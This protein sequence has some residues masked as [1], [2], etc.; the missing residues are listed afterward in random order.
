MP[1]V[2]LLICSMLGAC[3]VAPPD[4][5]IFSVD[6]AEVEWPTPGNTPIGY[7]QLGDTLELRIKAKD[8]RSLAFVELHAKANPDQPNVSVSLFLAQYSLRPIVTQ[9]DLAIN[10]I[11]REDSVSERVNTGFSETEPNWVEGIYGLKTDTL[12]EF[13]LEVWDYQNRHSREAYRFV[14]EE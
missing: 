12:Q 8:N 14:V 13:I 10:I 6:G 2:V 5:E 11:L 7:H 9:T 1:Y 4:V 3:V